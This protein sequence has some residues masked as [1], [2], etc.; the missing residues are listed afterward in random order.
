MLSPAT[1]SPWCRRRT[2]ECPGA[3]SGREVASHGQPRA[4]RVRAGSH[5]AGDQNGLPSRAPLTVLPMICGLE[6][7]S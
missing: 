7:A 5:A 3:A 1:A 2:T 6:T 4:G